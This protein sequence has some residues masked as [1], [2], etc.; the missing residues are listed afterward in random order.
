MIDV[1]RKEVYRYLGY[2]YQIPD[3]VIQKRV[4]EAI[5]QFE[6]CQ[7]R[8]V[9][10]EFDLKIHENRIEFESLCIRSRDLLKNLKGC[11][12]VVCMATTL[13]RFPDHLIQRANIVNKADAV[14]FQAVG[15]AMIEAYTDHINA[16][17]KEEALKRGYYCHPRYSCGYG[18]FDLGYQKD[19]IRILD[20]P[21]TIGVTLT[22]GNLMVPYKSITA[23]IGLSKETMEDIEN[24]CI[25]C[26]Q[27]DCIYKK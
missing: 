20:M 19:F 2:G 15:A 8:H 7:P 22:E 26:S 12:K 11:T 10:R 3:A 5:C 25:T 9:V 16:Q 23:L 18:D 27:K 21:K 13:G 1:S 14:I 17:I 24:S 6:S 4:E